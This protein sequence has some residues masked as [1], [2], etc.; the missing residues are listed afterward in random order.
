MANYNDSSIIVRADLPYERKME[1]L[2][3]QREGELKKTRRVKIGI[4]AALAFVILLAVLGV[5]P[6]IE[7]AYVV[8]AFLLTAGAWITQGNY[9]H[10]G[11]INSRMEILAT[12]NTS[13]NSAKSP[14]HGGCETTTWRTRR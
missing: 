2:D 8:G 10:I 3:K 5:F 13:C 12:E 7:A 9:T 14:I 6:R 1:L 11:I 4:A